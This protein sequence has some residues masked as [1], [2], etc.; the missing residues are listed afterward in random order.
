MPAVREHMI[1]IW[2]RQFRK[3]L[4]LYIFFIFHLA[5]F[6]IYILR[7]TRALSASEDSVFKM[8]HTS[9]HG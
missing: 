2:K 4:I 9:Q 7:S 8:I 3:E 6:S 1:Y 5:Y